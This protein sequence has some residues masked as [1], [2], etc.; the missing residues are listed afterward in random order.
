MKTLWNLLLGLAALLVLTLAF[1]SVVCA[2]IQ[3]SYDL[4]NSDQ[5][6]GNPNTACTDS[7]FTNPGGTCPGGICSTR[8]LNSMRR[9]AVAV[10]FEKP[11][12]KTATFI[13]Q[14][15]AS[16]PNTEGEAEECSCETGQII[17]KRAL[18]E[19]CCGIQ[20]GGANCLDAP[21]VIKASSDSNITPTPVVVARNG[22]PCTG[23]SCC[24]TYVPAAPTFTANGPICSQPTNVGGPL[25]L[26]VN[27][28]SLN[29]GNDCAF[30]INYDP[31]IPH[32][33]VEPNGSCKMSAV[34]FAS[35]AGN[36][37]VADLL[38]RYLVQVN[39]NGINGPVTFS[40]QDLGGV[41]HSF[42]INTG[43]LPT[44]GALTAA[45][46][47]G[48]SGLGLGL[49]VSVLS[50]PTLAQIP[51]LPNGGGFTLSPLIL[52]SNAPQVAKSFS[53]RGLEGQRIAMETSEPI[54]LF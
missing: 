40:V 17:V 22:A 34:F 46:A 7:S 2:Q 53:V 32:V 51:S 50:L 21:S 45:I 16:E 24:D 5:T 15:L 33:N 52:I 44:L 48:Y 23:T 1:P 25:S 27:E 38:S 20:G 37:V 30:D 11:N 31:A 54:V 6:T 35:S 10:K 18:D 3:A 19:L 43:L 47:S 42:T 26:S 14:G 9:L 13:L 29:G 12:K 36:T 4:P 41:D 28:T 49:N 8:E 39:P